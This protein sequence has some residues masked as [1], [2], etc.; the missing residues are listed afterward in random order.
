MGNLQLRIVKGYVKIMWSNNSYKP[1]GLTTLIGV[2]QRL[3]TP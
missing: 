1:Y 3:T 2:E